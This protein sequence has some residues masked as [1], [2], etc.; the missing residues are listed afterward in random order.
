MQK[1]R[2]FNAAEFLETPED[3]SLFLNEA[4]ATHDPAYFAHAVGVVARAKGMSAVAQKAGIA[5]EQ[6]YRS[7]SANGNPTMKSTFAVLDA[8]GIRLSVSVS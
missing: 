8:L 7:F 3:V 1:L 6:M 4:L 2:P 5:R